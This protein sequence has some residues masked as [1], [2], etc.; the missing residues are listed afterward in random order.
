MYSGWRQLFLHTEGGCYLVVPG[1]CWCQLVEIP[2]Q[3]YVNFGAN[4][5]DHCAEFAEIKLGFALRDA[6]AS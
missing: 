3:L 1:D 6:V 2:S 4:E 5:K